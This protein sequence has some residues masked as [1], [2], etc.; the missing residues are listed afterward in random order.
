MNPTG[1][2][3]V[4][5]DRWRQIEQLFHDALERSPHERTSFL[6]TAC[7]DDESLIPEVLQ[8]L[9]NHEN[10]K[11]FIEPPAE[12]IV[13][14]ISRQN[15]LGLQ[16]GNQ[17]G[18]FLLV[19]KLA[20]GG[21]GT[22]FEATQEHPQRTV[23]LKILRTGHTSPTALRR[24]EHESH[25]LAYL[26][27]PAI[28][29]VYETG[30]FEDGNEQVP[31][32]AMEYIP[33]A[34]TII[35]YADAAKLN[36]RQRL[37]LFVDVCDA[38]HHGHQRGIIH[39]DLKPG[40]ILVDASGRPKVIDFGVAR[41]T[42]SDLLVT[43]M[44]TD[45]GQLVGTLAYMSPE[46]CAAELHE[47]DT[48]S[49]V[50]SLGVVL[51]ELLCGRLPYDVKNKPIVETAQIIQHKAP[52]KPSS[53]TPQ[54][55]DDIETIILKAL[56][57]EPERRYQSAADLGADIRR[58]LN[59]RPIEAQ[60]P[61]LSYQLRLFARRNRVLVAAGFVLFIVLFA[62][63]GVITA[64]AIRADRAAQNA[65]QAARSE[66]Q[67]R[68]EA[69][70]I[71]RFL[72]KM[73]ASANPRAT[74][75]ETTVLT[76]LNNAAGRIEKDFEDHP[77]VE[78]ALHHTVG[79]TYESLGLFDQAENHLRK[80]LV[81]A[82]SYM[83]DDCPLL[84][85]AKTNLA[86]VLLE[87]AAYPEA[88]SL[89]REAITVQRQL[90]GDKR[91]A[92]A[93]SL[94]ALAQCLAD[95]DDLDSAEPYYREALAIRREMRGE[96]HVLVAQ[97]TAEL[98][99][100]FV[101]QGEYEEAESLYR[102]ALAINR[103]CGSEDDLNTGEF[104]H[105]LAGLLFEKGDYDEAESLI[106][107][108]LSIL[109]EY[110]GKEHPLVATGLNTLSVILAR[111]G[112]GDEAESALRECLAINR[113]LLGPEHPTVARFLLNLGHM[114]KEKG[115]YEEADSLYREA[116]S[117]QQK[118]LGT[119]HTDVAMTLLRLAT[120]AQLRGKYDSSESLIR[121]ALDI[122]VKR[123]GENHPH[124]ALALNDLGLVLVEQHKYAE[125]E[126]VL[127]D[128]IE[129]TRRFFGEHSWVTVVCESNLGMIRRVEGE[130][131]EA[132]SIYRK[133]LKVAELT[134]GHNHISTARS[135]YNLALV[136]RQQKNLDEAE[137]LF[138]DALRIY[139]EQLPEQHPSLA[140]PLMHLGSLLTAKGRPAQGETLLRESIRI[141]ST[142]LAE[143]HWRVAYARA[144]LGRCLTEL[145]RYD[146]AESVLTEALTKL[147][148]KL[149]EESR[150][151]KKAQKYLNRLAEL[152]GQDD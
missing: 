85:E 94:S 14:E 67:L 34:D 84:A 126:P 33:G 21:M 142:T 30:V 28:A 152:R 24:F 91:A 56:E 80:T 29:Q 39:R 44:H 77:S 140:L 89:I 54:L 127:Q 82:K 145:G 133:V 103:E 7:Q 114:L 12:A 128:A 6:S 102:R 137:S 73:L 50:Y 120:L 46:Q 96:S 130:L 143:G 31:Y 106:R 41:V 26:K 81:L 35:Q 115:D 150:Q 138:R 146:E 110:R 32:F 122:R 61:S 53:V 49:D 125:A 38:V 5:T 16:T 17:I 108:S 123:L 4:T 124:V 107:K 47:L 58:F 131:E 63:V 57:K 117:I 118:V 116:L 99:G 111:K 19:R 37:R 42:D 3:T 1:D 36:V 25:V 71:T 112:A 113:E 55:K 97:A 52:M 62:S 90:R 11:E 66:A 109:R 144:I 139:R 60:P 20:S 149:G 78:A 40:N 88:E 76:L 8:L 51:F 147:Q 69:E 2:R 129:K 74:G 132:E 86:K 101:K 13:T 10:A 83:D 23:A 148:T 79:V 87:K 68:I 15:T 75:K 9:S 121:Q 48:R 64:L 65:D 59:H 72:Q 22:V 18:S 104:M 27:H 105:N 136:L 135:R 45:V 141:Q 151:T 134:F 93:V 95:H 43:T 92:L 119:E 70:L 98:A 100:C